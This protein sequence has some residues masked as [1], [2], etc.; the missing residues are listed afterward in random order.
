MSQ[1]PIVRKTPNLIQPQEKGGKSDL[2]QLCVIHKVTK[3]IPNNLSIDYISPFLTTP[4][5]PAVNMWPSEDMIDNELP[6]RKPK[7]D[8]KKKAL[9]GHESKYIQAMLKNFQ[10]FN[11]KKRFQGSKG[12]SFSFLRI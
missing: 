10:T 6:P 1:A 4:H 5:L 7:N 8:N 2:A 3:N 9:N 11:N 12:A